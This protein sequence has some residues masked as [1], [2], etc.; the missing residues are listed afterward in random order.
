MSLAAEAITIYPQISRLEQST[1]PS[2][3]AP[4][5]LPAPVAQLSASLPPTISASPLSVT[6]S[7]SS[8]DVSDYRDRS[9]YSSGALPFVEE[10]SY[11]D[12]LTA[13]LSGSGQYIAMLYTYRSVSKAMPMV[14]ADTSDKDKQ[15][16]H[17]T[18]F[19]ILRPEM[20]KCTALMDFCTRA[21]KATVATVS[22]IQR[23]EADKRV[24]SD[25]LYQAVLQMLD[26][27]LLLDALKD[28]KTCVLNDFS[29]YKRAFTPIKATL[30]DSELLSDEIHQLQ[31]F[32]SYPASP[33]NLLYFHLKTDIQ[34]LPAHDVTLLNLLAFACEQLDK[35]RYIDSDEYHM[36]FRVLSHLLYLIDVEDRA[37]ATDRK[38]QPVNIFRYQGK[39]KLDLDR[40]KRYVR[41]MP[42]IPLYM[43]MHIDVLYVLKRISHFEEDKMRGDW[44]VISAAAY[45]SSSS[46]V[47]ASSRS[48]P[49]SSASP[50]GAAATGGAA[51]A[52]SAMRRDKVWQRYHLVHHRLRI[53]Q[54]Y[55][56]YCVAFTQQVQIIEQVTNNNAALNPTLLHSFFYLILTG[57]RLLA[58]WRAK[59]Q[60]QCAYKYAFPCPLTVYQQM[61]GQGGEGHEYEKAV[62]FNY[63]SEDLYALVDVLGTIKGLGELMCAHQLLIELVVRRT[64]HDDMQLFLQAEVGESTRKADK[65]KRGA[66][67]DV[68]LWMR[69]IAGDWMDRNKR[70]GW[71]VKQEQLSSSSSS[72]S[73]QLSSLELSLNFLGEANAALVVNRDFPLRAVAASPMQIAF[74]RRILHSI[75][76]EKSA[77]MQGG[78]FSEKDLRKESIGVW[79]DFYDLSFF[80]PYLLTALS[81]VR[82]AMDMSFLW[83]REFYLELTKC[84]QFP[85][86][87]SLP[88]ILTE[89]IINTGQQSVSSNANIL[90]TM[91]LYNDAAN[92]ALLEFKQQYLYDEV[93]A[94]CGVSFEQLVFHLSEAIW[95]YY[96]LHTHETNIKKGLVRKWYEHT[97]TQTHAH[98]ATAYSV[99]APRCSQP[100]TS[101]SIHVSPIVCVPSSLC[102]ALCLCLWAQVRQSAAEWQCEQQWQQQQQ[103]GQV[104]T[105]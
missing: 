21:V 24:P 7:L 37:A 33:H 45:D 72:S 86:S 100:L 73:A 11:L 76:S 9:G 88:W 17:L 34:K 101:C 36:Y 85:I 55:N 1:A 42:V 65:H 77:G 63:S 2:S 96:L 8:S 93:Q 12:P 80:Y 71:K 15:D 67:R 79:N 62:R 82:R 43:D 64:V 29:R 39:G 56:D 35:R 18:S 5:V 59:V 47:N 58:A 16:I 87:M 53:R 99:H 84:I 61:G 69:D 66:V 28:M 3:S 25:V 95:K 13:L 46:P 27:L 38:G 97:H 30:T 94:E 19:A 57:L 44:I 40:V 83:Y 104:L 74:M 50:T 105:A 41:L 78:L 14:Q 26:V 52:S 4:S 81:H 32:L 60:E 23:M 49:S 48:S 22:F 6:Y 51:G 102:S 90:Y 70:E 54:E 98:T 10:F 31:M 91:D 75:Y 68:M 92:T 89:F 103:A 20:Q